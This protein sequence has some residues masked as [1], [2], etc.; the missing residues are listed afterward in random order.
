MVPIRY[1]ARSL[2]VRKTSTFL[3]AIGI[4]LV[5][6]ALCASKMLANG[7]ER[8]LAAGGRDDVAIVLR[9]G[10]DAELGSTIED[11]QVSIITSQAQVKT[12]GG[13][14]VSAAEV[15]VVTASEKLG[16][17]GVT[18]LQVRGVECCSFAPA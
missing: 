2:F 5:V 8:T 18:N 1:N 6:F 9:K 17:D 13:K 14:P 16:A 4:G 10:S 11:A 12:Q 15:I 7:V 3:T